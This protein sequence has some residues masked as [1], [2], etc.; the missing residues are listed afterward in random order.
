MN[1]SYQ[2]GGGNYKD[3]VCSFTGTWNSETNQLTVSSIS[4]G[5]IA[6]G[7]LL[8]GIGIV[9]N[10]YILSYG[11]GIGGTGVYTLSNIQN[12]TGVN[13][14]CSAN[15]VYSGTKTIM[16]SFSRSYSFDTTSKSES[17]TLGYAQR[18]IQTGTSTSKSFSAFYLQFPPKSIVRPPQ[19]LINFSFYNLN[20][21]FLLNDTSSTGVSLSDMT[22]WNIIIEFVPIVN[23]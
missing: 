1:F 12:I 23:I 7:A 9:S 22:P 20:N 4:S 15:V 14:S 5:V 3:S 10:T 19:N 6:V 8:S 11:T 2:S 16:N 17:F 21:N 13:A 18:D